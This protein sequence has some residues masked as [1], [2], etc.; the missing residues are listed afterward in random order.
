MR[1]T[2]H[3]KRTLPPALGAA[4]WLLLAAPAPAPAPAQVPS[5][6]P[7][8]TEGIGIVEHLGETLPLD[9]VFTDESGATVTLGDLFNDDKPV[10]LTLVYYRCPSICNALL[11]G[12]V[13]TLNDMEW[14]A[15]EEFRIVVVSFDPSETHELADAKKKNYL[16]HYERETAADGWRFL[17]GEASSTETLA[18]AVGFGYRY[19][20]RTGLYTHAASLMVCT[21][22]GKLSRYIND[23][24]FETDTLRL[25]LTEAA[26]GTI[27][28]SMQR[29]LLKWCYT[30][31]P[32]AGKY[33]V[34]ARKVMLFGGALTV[35]VTFTVLGAVWR[36]ESKKHG[37]QKAD[38]SSGAV[39]PGAHT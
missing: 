7:A 2:I 5:D 33:V 24:M 35:I 38:A 18:E 15:G 17:V 19:E 21:P 20:P 9:L 11:N 36:Y 1:R 12:L 30:Y 25:A 3:G 23:V 37:R 31:D 27:G 6:E 22:D 8:D 26:E 32:G 13:Y 16:S 34:A 29:F 28:T 4:A 39:V 10:M 14:S